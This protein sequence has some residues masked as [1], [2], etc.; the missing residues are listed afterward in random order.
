MS[1]FSVPITGAVEPANYFGEGCNKFQFYLLTNYVRV[2]DT[3]IAIMIVLL[4]I[5]SCCR[6]SCAFALCCEDIAQ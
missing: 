6:N 1:K 5:V 4:F 3:W 2:S